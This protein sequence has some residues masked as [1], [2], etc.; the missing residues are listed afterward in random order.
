MTPLS[1]RLTDLPTNQ[2]PYSPTNTSRRALLI[3]AVGWSLNSRVTLFSKDNP[4]APHAHTESNMCLCAHFCVHPG[5]A[6]AVCGSAARMGQ[7]VS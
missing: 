7:N 4:H 6:R 1:L 2:L 3:D 5:C